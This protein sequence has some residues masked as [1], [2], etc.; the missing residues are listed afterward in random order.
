MAEL[1]SNY[2]EAYKL[3]LRVDC[4]AICPLVLD[5]I[6]KI[7]VKNRSQAFDGSV[8][9][10]YFLLADKVNKNCSTYWVMPSLVCA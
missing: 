1:S 8:Y 7:N 3:Y 9:F 4:D 10:D 6:C 2:N 5:G